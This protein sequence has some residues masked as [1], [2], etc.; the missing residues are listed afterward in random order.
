MWVSYLS[1]TR[2]RLREEERTKA[3]KREGG[4]GWEVREIPSPRKI[5][6]MSFFPVMLTGYGS[7]QH[8]SHALMYTIHTHA[9]TC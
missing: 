6:T 5:D 4:R 2:E 7:S 9:P 8:C 3:G 1:L